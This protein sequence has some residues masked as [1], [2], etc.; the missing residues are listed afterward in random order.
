MTSGWLRGPYAKFILFERLNIK[1]NE[2]IAQ[3]CAKDKATQ[4]GKTKNK[5]SIFREVTSYFHGL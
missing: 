1:T 3:G 4:N 5:E 2:N